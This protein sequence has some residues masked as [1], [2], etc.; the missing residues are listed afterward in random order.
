MEWTGEMTLGDGSV[1]KGATMEEA[2]QNLAKMKVDTANAYKTEKDARVA[3]ESKASA[4][5]VSIAQMNQPKKE[6]RQGDFDKDEYYR[7]LNADPVA[8]NDM[9]FQYRFKQSPDQFNDNFERYQNTVSSLEQQ[10]MAAQFAAQ[11]ADDFPH[12][13]EAAKA[14][15]ERV[16]VLSRQ[17]LPVNLTTLNYAY[18]QLVDEEIIKPVEKQDDP[19]PNPSISSSGGRDLGP[20]YSNA[21]TL[22]NADLEKLMR[23]SGMM[24]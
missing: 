24:R 2:F 23:K 4:Y 13:P 6:V 16:E 10:T 9:Y 15:R 14:M 21:E 1:V 11:H 18:S 3:A 5:E 19:A 7:L 22:S 12:S 17:G 8:A 20:E